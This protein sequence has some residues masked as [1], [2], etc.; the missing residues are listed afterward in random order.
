MAPADYKRGQSDAGGKLII[1][2]LHASFATR[3][4]AMKGEYGAMIFFNE[5]DGEDSYEF[6]SRKEKTIA[7]V[8]TLEEFLKLIRTM[9]KGSQLDLYNFCLSGSH[10]GYPEKN[11]KKIEEACKK[12]GVTFNTEEPVI[13]T[14]ENAPRT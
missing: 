7:A 14:C 12:A 1:L 11:W 5:E 9:P 3:N 8:G 6:Y 2:T 4:I 13:C 10:Y